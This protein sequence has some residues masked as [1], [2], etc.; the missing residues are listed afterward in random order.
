M[1]AYT[2]PK[3]SEGEIFIK[4]FLEDYGIRHVPQ[5]KIEKLL[6]DNK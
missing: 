4:E 1:I 5:K 3:I 6:F 2:A